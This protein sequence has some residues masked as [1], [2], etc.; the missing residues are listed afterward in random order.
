MCKIFDQWNGLNSILI[1]SS[2]NISGKALANITT[3]LMIFINCTR[4]F[5]RKKRG[6]QLR[7][8]RY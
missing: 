3:L 1:Q 7:R 8:V 5:K 6:Y 4:E 2:L